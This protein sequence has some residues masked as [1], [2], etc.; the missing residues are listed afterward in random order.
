MLAPELVER[1]TGIGFLEDRHNLRFGELRLAH[2]NL[3]AK[4]AIVPESSPYGPSQIRGS[5]QFHGTRTLSDS[6]L[7]KGLNPLNLQFDQ[8]CED[9]Y[10]LARHWIDHSQ[11]QGF[12]N[13]VVQGDGLE[14]SQRIRHRLTFKDDWGPHAVLVRDALIQPSRFSAV[15]YLRAPETIEDICESFEKHFGHD[16][17]ARFIRASRP[18]IVKIKEEP[19]RHDVV[20]SA[21]A[22]LWCWLREED[23]TMC[24]TCLDSTSTIIPPSSIVEIQEI[25]LEEFPSSLL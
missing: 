7:A 23:C 17:L 18:Y 24:N 13:G 21:L 12:K 11:W 9:L 5:L 6:S 20:G 16:L 2:G 4:V 25:S 1:A 15:N 10:V 3:L 22:Y 19:P 14:S 8:I